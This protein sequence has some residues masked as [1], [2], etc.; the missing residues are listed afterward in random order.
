[1]KFLE[2]SPLS[3]WA[4]AACVL[5]ARTTTAARRYPRTPQQRALSRC[6]TALLSSMLVGMPIHPRRS[7]LRGPQ[8]AM[9]A[10]SA[11]RRHKGIREAVPLLMPVL[12]LLPRAV[13]VCCCL[14]AR[15]L[16]SFLDHVDVGEYIV[17]GDL[18]AYSC[19]W[20]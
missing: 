13:V 1:M 3:R 16:N 4:Q 15:R 18:E 6:S 10:R 17:E 2:L 9:P 8:L 14:C 5:A 19:E 12:L 7:C 20:W 11:A